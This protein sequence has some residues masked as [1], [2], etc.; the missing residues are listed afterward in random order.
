MKWRVK[1]LFAKSPAVIFVVLGLAMM[2]FGWNLYSEQ[3][4]LRAWG[5]ETEGQI[6]GFQ[7]LKVEHE[8]RLKQNFVPVVMFKTESGEDVTFMGGVAERFWTDYQMGKTVLVVYNPESPWNARIN[9][10]AKIR[11]VPVMLFLFGL[12][13]ALLFS[14]CRPAAGRW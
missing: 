5:I 6:V 3:Q 1:S 10:L 14:V 13:V 12:G 7:R 8:N 4:K 11:F 2:F 9:E